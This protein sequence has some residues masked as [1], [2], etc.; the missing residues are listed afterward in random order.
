MKGASRLIASCRARFALSNGTC[1]RWSVFDF[2]GKNFRKK[3]RNRQ[4][5]FT[6]HD[7]RW[8]KVQAQ[9]LIGESIE[10]SRNLDSGVTFH[11]LQDGIISLGC[12]KFSATFVFV[13]GWFCRG[14]SLKEDLSRKKL[15]ALISHQVQRYQVSFKVQVVIDIHKLRVFRFE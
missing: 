6:W 3:K 8:L 11:A 4:R 14:L 13:F 9:Q 2:G 7:R 10:S 5:N 15:F 1:L 12:Q